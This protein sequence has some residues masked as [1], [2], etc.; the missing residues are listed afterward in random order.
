MALTKSDGSLTQLTASGNTAAIDV[1]DAYAATVSIIHA[2]GSG[3]ISSGG[4]VQPEIS[5]DGT[6]YR[7]D[8]GAFVFGTTASTT[9]YASY[10]PPTDGLA[11]KSVR[12]AWTVPGGS[13]G[14]TLDV[15]YT[16]T[17]AVS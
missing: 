2:T 4:E 7:P 10:T 12:F 14:H 3:T 16:K 6:N 8:G 13:T 1:S 17:T 9:E 11:V 5:H 15:E